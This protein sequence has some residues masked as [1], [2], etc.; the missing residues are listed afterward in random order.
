MDEAMAA[1]NKFQEITS[2]NEKLQQKKDDAYFKLAEVC[3]QLI[4]QGLD[5]E[6]ENAELKT[7]MTTLRETLDNI[8]KIKYN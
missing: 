8:K 6:S 4:N 5:I 3:E 1:S 7:K 2:R